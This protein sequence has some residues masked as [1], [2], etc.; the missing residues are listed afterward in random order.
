MTE[1]LEDQPGAEDR[2]RTA[3]FLA[4]FSE[5]E[6]LLKGRLSR[7]GNVKA[8]DLIQEY[9]GLN[10]YWAKDHKDLERFRQ[11]RNFLTHEQSDQH[12]FP[13]VV[14]LRS[15][16]RLVEIKQGLEAPV[17]ISRRH[18]KAV[19]TVG[20]DASL[21]A[22]LKLAYEKEFSQ[23]PVVD[24]GGRFRGLVTENEITRWL[25]RQ[26]VRKGATVD[27]AGVAVRSVLR[28]KESDRRQVPIFRFEP[29]EEPEAEVMGLFMKHPMLEVVLLTASGTKTSRIEGIVTQWDAARYP[30]DDFTT[31]SPAVR[32]EHLPGG[33]RATVRPPN[34]G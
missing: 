14:T 16:A 2:N 18:R 11:I 8:A 4:V 21:A 7:K 12:G 3:S 34:P 25:G 27:L 6:Q 32:L 1:P 29:L 13:V 22:V 33:S 31:W 23:F 24:A 19:T 9:L 26:A 10:P 30:P 5:I 17:P 15:H 20:P 28:E